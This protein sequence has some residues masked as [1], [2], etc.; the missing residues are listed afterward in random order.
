MEDSLVLDQQSFVKL[1][2]SFTFTICLLWIVFWIAVAK[3][4]ESPSEILKD[5]ALLEGI[6]VSFILSA[7]VILSLAR[8]L[9]RDC[10]GSAQWRRRIRSGQPGKETRSGELIIQE[11]MKF[12][13]G[14]QLR[15]VGYGAAIWGRF[16]CGARRWTRTG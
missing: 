6:T 5:E 10:S 4:N 9:R 8:I 7:V 12:A 13:S 14:S 1:M 2:L 15:T 16:D 11:Y 3:R